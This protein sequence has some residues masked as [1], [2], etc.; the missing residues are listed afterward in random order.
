[1]KNIY[2]I[3]EYNHP[4]NKDENR[5]FAPSAAAKINYISGVLNRLGYSVT[6]VSKSP[7]LNQ[8]SCPKKI[9]SLSD[10]LKL[11]LFY[12]PG[13]KNIFFRVASIVFLRLQLLLF[14]LFNTEKS[15]TV[16]SYHSLS[17]I[18][19][20]KIAKAIKK[21]RLIIEVEEIYGDVKGD[22]KCSEKE[23]KFFRN[24][25]DSYIFSTEILERSVNKGKKPFVINYGEYNCY[26]RKSN[27]GDGKIHCVYAGTF[28]KTKKGAYTA[29]NSAEFLTE[30]YHMHILGFG[31]PEE[32][33]AIKKLIDDVSSRSKA[34]VSYDGIKSGDEYIDFLCSCDIGVSS[35]N[36]N[37][38][39]NNTS[40][41][42]KVLS[43]FSCGLT[44]VSVDIPVLRESKVSDCIFFYYG[45][46]P[47]ALAQTIMSVSSDEYESNSF[48][49]IRELNYEFTDSLKK[50]IKEK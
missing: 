30:K 36:P 41:P 25:A 13:R 37:E 22:K 47:S 23:I 44:V 27:F 42:S 49:V 11:Q 39:F 33:D 10:K 40:F 46:N 8:K 50:I 34:V 43:Y 4:V 21:F 26:Q 45:D 1:M 16:I 7:T 20:L 18:T 32:V 31:T 6:I 9:I 3:G 2:Y 14:L 48:S 35:Q 17:T 38:G 15:D 28:D 5:R 12:S 29:I 19:I 24:T